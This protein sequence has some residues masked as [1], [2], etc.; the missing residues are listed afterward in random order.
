M[1]T[2]H[3]I[4]TLVR[5][6]SSASKRSLKPPKLSNQRKTGDFSSSAN[7]R[8]ISGVIRPSLIALARSAGK[9]SSERPRVDN[10]NKDSVLFPSCSSPP[11]PSAPPP[12]PPPSPPQLP[13]FPSPPPTPVLPPSPPPSPTSSVAAAR[14]REPL[15]FLRLLHRCCTSITPGSKKEE[16]ARVEEGDSPPHRSCWYW[17]L[18]PPLT[19]QTR[20]SPQPAPPKAHAR[21]SSTGSPTAPDDDL[22]DTQTPGVNAIPRVAMAEEATAAAE[23]ETSFR[24]PT[25]VREQSARGTLPNEEKPNQRRFE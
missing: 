8:M 9:L 10:T 4:P 21:L 25:R 19:R 12:P 20:E 22:L 5:N 15:Q 17:W 18:P 6:R 24:K 13:P 16:T 23:A 2:P 1:P 7:L 11:P 3:S 14:I